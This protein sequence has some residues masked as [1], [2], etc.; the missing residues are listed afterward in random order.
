VPVHLPGA[1]PG[2]KELV[3]STTD[4]DTRNAWHRRFAE[5]F[6][7][8]WETGFITDYL[9]IHRPPI[10][11]LPAQ[12]LSRSLY[13]AWPADQLAMNLE[14]DDLFAIGH[15]QCRVAMQLIGKGCRG[16][17]ETC[18]TWG[19]MARM[20]IDRGMMR[21][22][23][24]TEILEVKAR[25]ESKGLVTWTMNETSGGIGNG[26][27]SCCGCC[28]HGLRT[29]SEFN[30]PGLSCSPHY[31]PVRSADSCKEGCQRCATVCPV[32]DDPAMR[33]SA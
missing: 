1:G 3:L 8:I 21:R 10:R 30:A 15:C 31:M 29:L 24:A 7:Q 11:A 13:R 20:F 16:A 23:D 32:G 19:P 9:R 26:A 28:C 22:T 17:T 27:C 25:A 33:S 12:Q 14:R 2:H 18:V 6:E 4:L 5:L